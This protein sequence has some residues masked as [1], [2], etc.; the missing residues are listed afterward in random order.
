MIKILY[1]AGRNQHD[2]FENKYGINS[3]TGIILFSAQKENLGVIS[4]CNGELKSILGYSSRELIG[5]NIRKLIPS[6]R[7]QKK[8]EEI[9]TNFTLSQE[10]EKNERMEEIDLFA[11]NSA[12][13]MILVTVLPH[14]LLSLSG[15]LE[16][17]SF[18]NKQYS[19]EQTLG[20]EGGVNSRSLPLLLLDFNYNILGFSQNISYICE[21]NPKN[22]DPSK[23]FNAEKRINMQTLYPELFT[24]EY[25]TEMQIIGSQFTEFNFDPLREALLTEL[26]EVS[27][28]EE[29]PCAHV[30]LMNI[31]F[32]NNL[33][34]RLKRFEFGVGRHFYIMSFL[35]DLLLLAPQQTHLEDDSDRTQDWFKEVSVGGSAFY[36]IEVDDIRSVSGSSGMYIY[37][38]QFS[39]LY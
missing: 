29:L 5:E 1:R 22:L 23:Y 33:N 14:F 8:L 27:H 37:I 39:L 30:G 6:R 21:V 3:K 12:G 32:E 26:I 10:N 18:I 24:H 2:A 38:N 13:F 36:D 7:L 4:K 28:L 17:F 15:G 31:S 25:L 11:L 9:L 19:L 16:I 20:I 35:S 34:I